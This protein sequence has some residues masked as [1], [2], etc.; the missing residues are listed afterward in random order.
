[1]SCTRQIHRALAVL[2]V[3]S[4][5]ALKKPG[6]DEGRFQRVETVPATGCLPRA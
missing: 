4:R 2:E 3:A 5:I 1:M 6:D